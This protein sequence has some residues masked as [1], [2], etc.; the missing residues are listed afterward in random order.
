M[1]ARLSTPNDQ[2]SAQYDVVIIGSGY[3]GSIAASR[4]ARAVTKHGSGPGPTVCLL[5]R[6]REVRAGEYATTAE[7]F[8]E[9]AQVHAAGEDSV[10]SSSAMYEFSVNE[11]IDVFK[12]CGLGGT[13]LVNANV[14]LHPDHR[15]FE[16]DVWPRALRDDKT[17]LAQGFE[18]AIHML[19]PVEYPDDMP[20]LAKQDAHRVSAEALGRKF[21]L[22]PINVHFKDAVNNAGVEQKAC[23]LCG[24]CV[25]G[26][27]HDA[28]NTLLYN[29][30]PDA[31]RH[32]AEIFCEIDVRH[33]ERKNGRF[34]VHFDRSD[35]P[36]AF[37]IADVVIL[38]AGTLGSTEI[39]LRSKERG[40]AT[41][42]MVGERF[43]GNGDMLGFAYNTE[44]HINGVGAGTHD[45]E[46]D[47]ACGPCITSIIDDSANPDL[48]K[49]TIIEEGSI[50]APASALLPWAF[51]AESAA[52]GENTEVDLS[53]RLHEVGRTLS[54]LFTSRFGGA[55]RGAVRNTQTY[56]AMAHDDD[57]GRMHLV[58]DKLRIAWP[59][60]GDTSLFERI[61]DDLHG[62]T[63][64]LGGTYI[65]NPVW[66]KLTKHNLITV[67]PL[68]GCILGDSAEL[69][70]V[71]H[72]GQVFAGAVGHEV[73][74]GLY[75][76]DG[77][78]VP[79]PLGVNPLLTISALAE[80]CVQLLADDR[81]W[82]FSCAATSA[83]LAPGADAKV[84]VEFTEAMNGFFAEGQTSD[85]EQGAAAGKAAGSSLGF[86]LTIVSRD[87]TAMIDNAAHQAHLTGTVFAPALSP[88]PMVATD[89]VFNLFTTDDKPNERQMWYR[90]KLTSEDGRKLFFVAFKTVHDDP[91][92][93]IWDDSTTLFTTLH[94][95]HDQGGA[96]LGKGIL[97]IEVAGVVDLL[98][99]MKITSADGVLDRTAAMLRFARFF[100]GS[101]LEEF[102]KPKLSL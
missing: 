46:L 53:H 94:E 62:A 21:R 4:L 50:P 33:V 40:L 96:V 51:A 91:G 99:T 63:E 64:P 102:V 29:Y 8:V 3:G 101:L 79:C 17:G 1:S 32:G 74:D 23:T 24:D 87:L 100:L 7:E 36:S 88:H 42:G 75:V 86:N 48:S 83:P 90:M 43:T 52:V 19:Q 73:Y 68:G 98:E 6:G 82:S 77:A 95:G 70:V 30:L 54:S 14:S 2:I 76:S 37:V 65:K 78:V 56:L 85:Y 45:V 5:E 25:S 47:R 12:G 10:G 15:V 84:G 57:A 27:N 80:R 26:C 44:R 9:N 22:A 97:R 67:H 92:F 49:A 20:R 93:D 69:G 28:K 34:V 66:N 13:S 61:S 41:S 16:R 60:I 71:N 39:L 58:G 38:A 59:G 89:G 81:G 11:D 35:R 31:A 18:R 55:Y 72:K